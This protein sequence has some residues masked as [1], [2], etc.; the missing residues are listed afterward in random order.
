MGDTF[1]SRK[2]TVPALSKASDFVTLL[3]S[4]SLEQSLVIKNGLH[5]FSISHDLLPIRPLSYPPFSQLATPEQ[6]LEV[7]DSLR[8]GAA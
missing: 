7:S 3:S 2:A 5:I 8:L 4:F 6:T 1:A